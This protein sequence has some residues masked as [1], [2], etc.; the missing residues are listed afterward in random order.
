MMGRE[1]PKLV[2]RETEFRG[3]PAVQNRRGQVQVVQPTRCLW[4][5]EYCMTQIPPSQSDR[6]ESHTNWPQN[7]FRVISRK[8]RRDWNGSLVRETVVGKNAPGLFDAHVVAASQESRCLWYH[9]GF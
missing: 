1:V 7:R 4:I 9:N 6:Y 3:Q 2:Y 5:T 8:R